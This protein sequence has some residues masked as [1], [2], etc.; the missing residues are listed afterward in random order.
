[1]GDRMVI[2]FGFPKAF[3]GKGSPG[4]NSLAVLSW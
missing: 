1:M 4:Y 3:F 2:Y